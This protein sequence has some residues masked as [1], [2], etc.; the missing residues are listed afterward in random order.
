MFFGYFNFVPLNKNHFY[1][2]CTWLYISTTCGWSLGFLS[3]TR[4]KHLPASLTPQRF[5]CTPFGVVTVDA[6]A[7]EASRCAPGISQTLALFVVAL[8]RPAEK[9]D[10]FPVQCAVAAFI[11]CERQCCDQSWAEQWPEEA[12]FILITWTKIQD[13]WEILKALVF[14]SQ[15]I[16]RPFNSFSNCLYKWLNCVYA[17]VRLFTG[18]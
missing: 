13:M 11:C 15:Y 6:A 4:R 1:C 17:Y 12:S 16:I 9:K 8:R 14:L 3:L 10:A 18:Q 5:I 2:E 7:S